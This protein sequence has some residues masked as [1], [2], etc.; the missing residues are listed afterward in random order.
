MGEIGLAT[1]GAG[2]YAG[3]VGDTVRLKMIDGIMQFGRRK[4]RLKKKNET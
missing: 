2:G 4:A 3:W 1:R